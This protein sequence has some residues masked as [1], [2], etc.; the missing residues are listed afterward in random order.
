[1]APGDP[2]T[3]TINGNYT[4]DA[5]GLLVIDIAGAT[6]LDILD[7][8]GNVAL[9]GD[10]V[11]NFLNGYVPTANTQFSFLQTS[12]TV[13]GNF[14]AIDVNGLNCPT[15]SFDLS[16]L[17]LDIGSTAPTSAV[18]EPCAIA[19]QALGSVAVAVA[20]KRVAL[21]VSR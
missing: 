18:P 6:D 9:S 7:V 19:L 4:Q 1:M 2:Q 16:T 3:L 13:S 20:R 5:T 10:V 8:N 14:A 12:G 21:L 15:C 11:V 17:S